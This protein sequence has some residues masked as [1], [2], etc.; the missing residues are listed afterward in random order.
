VL[1]DG[2]GSGRTLPVDESLIRAVIETASPA[3]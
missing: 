1:P 2:A 3:S